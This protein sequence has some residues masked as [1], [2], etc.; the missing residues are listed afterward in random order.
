[1]LETTADRLPE[2]A[3]RLIP[4]DL[5]NAAVRRA[6]FAGANPSYALVDDLERPTWCLVRDVP[7]GF[8]FLGGRPSPAEIA[9]AVQAMRRRG[10][11]WIV[12]REGESRESLGAPPPTEGGT[13]AQDE[14]SGRASRAD[15]WA[16]C[17]PAGSEL[18]RVDPSLLARCAWRD[19]VARAFGG[20]EQYLAASLGVCLLR[21]EA[22]LSEAH[23][24]FWA[25]GE[26]EIGAVTAKDV[27]GYGLA[28][29][30]AARLIQECAAHGASTVWSCAEDNPASARVAQ[31]LGYERHRRDALLE[32]AALAE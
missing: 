16:A 22:I 20:A 1:M 10:T 32:Y 5:P 3:R 26:A 29:I 28:E 21:G 18:R 19:D 30:V 2:A 25:G 12:L 6:L 9:E 13:V 4:E 23:A 27:R 11:F 17:V 14:F 31:K 24:F 8:A 7:C 15:E